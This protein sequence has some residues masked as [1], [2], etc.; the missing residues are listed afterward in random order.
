MNV[1]G[2]NTASAPPAAAWAT[3]DSVERRLFSTSA[4]A[5]IWMTATCVVAVMAVLSEVPMEC[6][7]LHGRRQHP[8]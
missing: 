4:V 2:A 6:V 3:S 7:G 5:H 1:S 8:G